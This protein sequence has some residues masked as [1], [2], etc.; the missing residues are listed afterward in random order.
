[1]THGHAEVTCAVGSA[2]TTAATRTTASVGTPEEGE[3]EEK[4]AE[5]SSGEESSADRE[6][7]PNRV[8]LKQVCGGGQRSTISATHMH[9]NTPVSVSPWVDGRRPGRLRPGR[10]HFPPQGP[11]EGPPNVAS[12]C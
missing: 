6:L 2:R 7:Q 1:M 11:D 12:E 9:R 4:I 5:K 3:E 10:G 8:H